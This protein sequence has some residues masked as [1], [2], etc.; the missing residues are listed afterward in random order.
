M[1]IIEKQ[2]VKHY[3]SSRAQKFGASRAKAQGWI[4]DDVQ[5]ARFKTITDLVD[6]N[7]KSILDLGCGYGDFKEVLDDKFHRFDYIGIDQQAE[8]ITYAEERFKSHRHTW[9]HHVDFSKCQLPE[10][11][12][13]VASGVLSYRSENQHYYSDMIERFYNAAQKELVFNMLDEAHFNSGPLIIAH[14]PDEIV[15]YCESLCD[16]VSVHRGYLENDFTVL[17]AKES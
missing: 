3:H 17:M 10:V 4:N 5:Q 16:D 1:N 6:F 12:V 7:D 14:N 13:V 2:Q 9:F 11:D 8:F 15:R